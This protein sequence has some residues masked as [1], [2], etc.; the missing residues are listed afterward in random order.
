VRG[1]DA[2]GAVLVPVDPVADNR[3]YEDSI[4]PYVFNPIEGAID[5]EFDP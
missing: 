5:L 4:T 1:I 2:C 3:P